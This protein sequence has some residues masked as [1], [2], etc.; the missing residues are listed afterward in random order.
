MKQYSFEHLSSKSTQAALVVRLVVGVVVSCLMLGVDR[1]PP[2]AMRMTG[3]K[4]RKRRQEEDEKGE[5][6][7]AIGER[8]TSADL[9]APLVY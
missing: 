2:G 9:Y 4:R 5:S 6:S 3:R 1:S 8:M 7:M